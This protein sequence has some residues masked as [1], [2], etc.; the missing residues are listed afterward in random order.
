MKMKRSGWIVVLTAA[1][2]AVAAPQGAVAGEGQGTEGGV[3]AEP[4][5]PVLLVI[6]GR[7][8][9]NKEDVY[10]KYI[11][12]TRPLM[13]KYGVEIAGVGGGIDSGHTT[14]T[15]PVNAILRFPSARAAEGFFSDPDYEA[16]KGYRDEAYAE[17][18]LS[19]FHTREARTVGPRAVAEKAFEHFQHGLATGEWGGFLGMLTED[20]TFCFPQ[21]QWQGCHEGRDKADQFLHYVSAAFN[22]GLFVKEVVRV[23]GHGDTVVFEFWD[24]GKLF[25][26]MYDNRIAISLDIRGDKICGY[27]EYFGKVVIPKSPP[28]AK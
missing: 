9:A 11:A 15:W 23:T 12:G 27:R 3:M 8:H 22:E 25:G 13:E 26:K 19:L 6:Q 18:Q 17:M 28:P 10:E 16:I 21:G 5:V 1:L 14:A 2:A 7:L 24:E 20:F 4:Q